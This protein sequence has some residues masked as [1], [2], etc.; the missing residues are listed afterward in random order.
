MIKER[1]SG[2]AA[3]LQAGQPMAVNCPGMHGPMRQG[4]VPM[5]QLHA[6]M[7]A[8]GHNHGGDAVI[9]MRAIFHVVRAVN[10]TRH[11]GIAIVMSE[12][13]DVARP[14]SRMTD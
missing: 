8:G 13:A 14:R 3:A 2:S 4:M 11:H 9:A 12:S 7:H 6:G 1:L 10:E 5:N